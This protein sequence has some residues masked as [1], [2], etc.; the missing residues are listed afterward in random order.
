M[1]FAAGEKEVKLVDQEQ[2]QYVLEH[3]KQIYSKEDID[4]AFDRLAKEVTEKLKDQNPLFVC[5]LNGAIIPTAE[6][7]KRLDF[8]LQLD[9]I[10]ATRYQGKMRGSHLNIYAKPRIVMRDRIVVLVEDIIDTGKTLKEIVDYCYN[11]GARHVY[12][13][14]MLDKKEARDKE[15]LQQ[16]DF[17]G[18]EVPNKFLVGYG[19]DY[20]EYY[21]NLDHVSLV[22]EDHL[23]KD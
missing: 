4:N 10:H 12:T 19:L 5:V 21:R 11:E 3:A 13:A 14:A 9:H 22:S 8:P 2:Y 18:I 16:A 20:E 6:L 17:V 23:F 7:L 1:A 15:G